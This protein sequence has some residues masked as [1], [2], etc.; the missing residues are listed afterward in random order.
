[1]KW[2]G[3]TGGI[4]TG[5]SSAAR[6]IEGLGYPVIDADQIAHK[7]SEPKKVGYEKIVDFFG[8]NILN[9]DFTIDRKK[10]GQLIF[11]D[12]RL[13][14]ELENILHPLI[15]N[16]VQ[17]QKDKYRD[18]GKTLCFYDVPLLFEKN[19]QY[20][21]DAT[22]LV[23]CN[24][25]TQIERLSKRNNLTQEEVLLRLKNQ[26][27]LIEKVKLARFCIDNSGTKD[28]LGKQTQILIDSL[29]TI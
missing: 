3:L 17:L 9:N 25:E 10:L 22:V 8:P 24:E 6:L 15:R 29:N 18:L 7:L 1:M 14:Y 26:T 23:W 27:P 16:E 19:L 21:F 11:S 12:P 13:K 5:K 28:E 4:A 20:D 2:I